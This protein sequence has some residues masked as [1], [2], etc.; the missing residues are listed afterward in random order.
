MPACEGYEGTVRKFSAEPSAS[1]F[2]FRTERTNCPHHE[3]RRSGP[4]LRGVG[5]QRLELIRYWQ[6]ALQRRSRQVDLFC[7]VVPAP[8]L[9]RFFPKR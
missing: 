3:R 4:I 2:T 7:Q 8:Q 1:G 9:D 6:I 5:M